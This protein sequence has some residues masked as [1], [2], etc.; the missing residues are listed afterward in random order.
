MSE[1][2]PAILAADIRELKDKI[3]RLPEEIM[4]AHIDVLEKDVWTEIDM[5]FEAHLMV[6]GPEKI[7]GRWV[8]RG[9]KRIIL[10][11]LDGLAVKPD[12][13]EIG[14]GVE[15]RVPLEAVFPSLSRVDFVH[16][17]SIA[18]IG[19][20]GHPFEPVIFDRIK[21]VK[22]RFPQ[23]PISVDGGINTANYQA[24]TDSGA[25]RLTVGSGFKDLWNSLTKK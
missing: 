13:V 7:I 6:E 9:A 12:G 15:L 18:E 17:M 10:H 22:E 24:L 3:S 4:F 11:S 16:L 1:I 21:E 2:I 23:L 19:E 14:L 20:Q 8:K 5:G 25:D